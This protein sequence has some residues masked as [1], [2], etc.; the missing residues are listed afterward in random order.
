MSGIS[1]RRRDGE[2]SKDSLIA[3]YGGNLV[4]LVV[5]EEKAGELREG[6]TRLPSIQISGRA[7]CDLE[8]IATGGFSPLDRFMAREDFESVVDCM[9]LADGTLF[10]VPVTLP[11]ERHV[12]AAL[13]DRVA[14]RDS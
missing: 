1:R 13:D 14:L 4:N 12:G 7:A 10:P 9:R 2:V 6:A 3:L 5:S 8:L 11:V